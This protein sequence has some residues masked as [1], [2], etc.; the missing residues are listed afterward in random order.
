M[1]R[2][3]LP[4]EVGHDG[5][6]VG[7]EFVRALERVE[8][9][10]V[11]RAAF[12]DLGH[13]PPLDLSRNELA[14]R[15]ADALGVGDLPEVLPH[16]VGDL[17]A[18]LAI[19]ERRLAGLGAGSFPASSSHFSSVARTGLDP[20]PNSYS[21]MR[22]TKGASVCRVLAVESATASERVDEAIGRGV[23][24]Q[25]R[26]IGGM[27]TMNGRDAHGDQLELTPRIGLSEPLLRPEDA[28]ELLSVRVSWIYE[29]CRTGRLPFL[30]VGKHIRF[31]RSELERWLADRY[32]GS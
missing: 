28:A 2:L 30:R 26:D 4:L 13:T 8:H 19:P 31:T 1:T 23:A 5:G 6:E 16:V 17:D 3:L 20:L 29:A 25:M 22:G 27:T 10:T 15:L 21:R 9:R 18:G 14:K 11:V 24:D 7:L 32:T 12:P